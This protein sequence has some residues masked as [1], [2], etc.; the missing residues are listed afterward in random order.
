MI[1]LYIT[2]YPFAGRKSGLWRLH[3]KTDLLLCMGQRYGDMGT[4]QRGGGG[5]GAQNLHNPS[6]VRDDCSTKYPVP[7]QPQLAW[8]G[9]GVARLAFGQH[10]SRLLVDFFAGIGRCNLVV[11]DLI[12]GW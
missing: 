7:H 9:T 3:R 2:Q 1:A 12:K 6:L 10:G 4:L 8:Y 11:P 5:S